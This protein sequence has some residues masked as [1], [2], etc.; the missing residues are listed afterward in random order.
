[1]CRIGVRLGEVRAPDFRN[2]HISDRGQD[3]KPEQG[4]VAVESARL[5]LCL[6]AR[7]HV[8]T[9]DVSE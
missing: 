6:D 5:A 9:R 7:P 8:F 4:F 1:M 2:A 3:V